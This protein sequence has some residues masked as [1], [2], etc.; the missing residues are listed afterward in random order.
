MTTTILPSLVTYDCISKQHFAWLPFVTIG[1]RYSYHPSNLGVYFD[2]DDLSSSSLIS[3]C[4]GWGE[5]PIIV[6]SYR[7]IWDPTLVLLFM[8]LWHCDSLEYCILYFTFCRL[9]L[10]DSLLQ[11]S[12]V[13]V[14]I[15]GRGLS[16]TMYHCI[17]TPTSCSHVSIVPFCY[18]VLL[19]SWI[20]YHIVL[21]QLSHVVYQYY[22]GPTIPYCD[23]HVS[24]FTLT[25]CPFLLSHFM[26]YCFLRY[27]YE[28][29]Y[30]ELGPFCQINVLVIPRQ[31]RPVKLVFL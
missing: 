15:E 18:R 2:S 21:D 24:I 4:R 16:I 17:G 27:N 20:N 11:C 1:I 30:F 10:C 6:W 19:L 23:Y 3:L 7:F 25:S 8:A 14:Y 5:R 22:H 28:Q 26:D 13:Q 12:F 31:R 29:H 9:P